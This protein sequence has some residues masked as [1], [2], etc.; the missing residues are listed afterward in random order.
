MIDESHYQGSV[1]TAISKA[2]HTTNPPQNPV[3]G[4]VLSVVAR[5]PCMTNSGGNSK[6]KPRVEVQ[7]RHSR[8]SLQLVALSERCLGREGGRKSGPDN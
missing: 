6:L 5:L 8:Q 1:C 4:L 2:R 3:V 7:C